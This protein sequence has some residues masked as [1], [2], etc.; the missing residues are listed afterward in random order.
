MSK[1]AVGLGLLGC[2]LGVFVAA[3]FL[4]GCETAKGLGRDIQQADDWIKDNLW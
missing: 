1:R 4:C 2:L 3:L